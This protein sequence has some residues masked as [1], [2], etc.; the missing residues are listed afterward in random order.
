MKLN[1]DLHPQ[2]TLAY[3]SLGEVYLMTGDDEKALPAVRKA[4][5]LDPDNGSAKGMLEYLERNNTSSP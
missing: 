2:S 1:A 5:E 4:L 3:E